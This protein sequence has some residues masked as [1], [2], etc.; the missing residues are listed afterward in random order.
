M[1]ISGQQSFNL[2]AVWDFHYRSKLPAHQNG[3]GTRAAIRHY[4]EFISEEPSFVA[5]DFNNNVKWDK[6]NVDYD[7][8]FSHTV[9]DL[10]K[11]GFYS[12]YHQFENCKYG[13][14][15]EPTLYWRMSTTQV[16]H[17]DYC[18]VPNDWFQNSYR[19]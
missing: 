2:L 1:K 16:Y 17:I 15:P 19:R 11:L 10:E 14:E 8:N 13:E 7:G 5:G 9:Y 3:A 6:Q 4:R 12:A 18:F